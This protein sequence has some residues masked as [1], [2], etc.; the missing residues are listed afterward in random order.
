MLRLLRRKVNL[1]SDIQL[2]DGNKLIRGEFST[3]PA[4]VSIQIARGSGNIIDIGEGAKFNGNILIRGDN[5]KITIGKQCQWKGQIVVKG[6]GQTVHIGDHSTSR[7][8]YILCQENCN[9]TIGK[10][11][12]FSRQVEV[13]TT[14]AHSVIDRQT[15]ERLNGAQ[16]V[17]IGDHVWIGVGALINKGAFVPS[18]SIVGAMSFVSRRFDEEGVLI[19]GVPADIIRRGITWDRSR[20]KKYKLDQLDHW[21]N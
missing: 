4:S 12:M 11:C 1:A 17:S 3:I 7:D 18:D 13:R 8:C 16:S 21:R 15:G 19:A 2:G 14:D 20:K 5:N 10:W 6:N 9:V